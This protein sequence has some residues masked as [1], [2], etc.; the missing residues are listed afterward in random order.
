MD[1]DIGFSPSEKKRPDGESGGVL[2]V[3]DS[4]SFENGGDAFFSDAETF[5]PSPGGAAAHVFSA[6]LSCADSPW[7]DTPEPACAPRMLGI[8]LR[9]AGQVYFIS[10]TKHTVRVGSKVI[11]AFEQGVSLGEVLFIFQ[12]DKKPVEGE[13]GVLVPGEVLGL[14]TAKDIAQHAENSIL[15]AEASA[16][17]KS[18]IRHRSLD[19]KL[20][21]VE[22]LHDRSKIIFFFTAPSR[23]DFRELVKDL[24]R[25]YHTRIEL[26]QIGVRHETQMIGGLGNCGMVC[27]CHRYLRKFA[28]VTI[29]MAKEQN[30][31][32]NP[33]KLSG[34]CGR[35]L[36]CLSFEQ[37]NYEEFNRRCPKLGKK[38][39]TGKGVLKVLRANLFNRS[40]VALG[41]TGEEMEMSL[42]EWHD[43]APKRAEAVTP[44][45]QRPPAPRGENG[46]PGDPEKANAPEHE[47]GRGQS[48]EPGRNRDFT[49]N[50]AHHHHKSRKRRKE[51]Q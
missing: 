26:R 18:C 9:K 34:M 44:D 37:G 1:E 45:Q 16:F 48:S 6:G 7:S 33:A 32:L 35:L 27:C 4:A 13:E 29:K 3:P 8:R 50:K 10:D 23:I 2:A 28:P 17:C 43:L 38:Y 19:M 39:I 31:F 36:C 49:E 42:E 47:E 22:V 46:R 30:L 51:Q 24:V 12:G 41:E 15:A 21:D 25:N 14:A 40:V 5:G 20:V 11:V